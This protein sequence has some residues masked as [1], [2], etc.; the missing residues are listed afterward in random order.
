[1]RD[2]ARRATF[3]FG[4][5][6]RKRGYRGY[7]ECDY[8]YDMD[9]DDVY[10]G[11][12]NPRVTGASS[13]TNLA[14]FAQADAPLFLFHLLEWAGVNFDL[15]VEALNSRWADPENI[16]SW[17]QLVIKF[18]EDS[19]EYVTHAPSSGIW[20][21]DRDGTVSFVRMQTHRR[22]AESESEAFFLRI[23][24]PGDYFYEGADLGYP[25]H[26]GTTHDGR[27]PAQREG[28]EVDSRHP[29]AVRV[30]PT[31][32]EGDGARCPRRRGGWFQVPLSH[33]APFRG[34]AR[35]HPGH[36]VEESLRADLA[37]L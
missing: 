3:K 21:M 16:D 30:P 2:R 10:L 37:C 13:M 9:T 23:T 14:A 4:E 8:L 36:E 32:G 1:M 5:A 35:A 25:R 34:D 27:L 11:E 28:Q 22:T 17:S 7:F 24:R 29:G 31:R 12:V 26:P 15:N 19:V 6:L 20:H 33:A 18:P